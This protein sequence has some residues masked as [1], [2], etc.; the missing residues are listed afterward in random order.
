[1]K[2]ETI[3]NLKLAGYFVG[4]FVVTGVACVALYKMIGFEMGKGFALGLAKAGA[5]AVVL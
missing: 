5:K 4:G 2:E 1:M 3:E